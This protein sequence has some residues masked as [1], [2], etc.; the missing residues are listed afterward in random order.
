MRALSA[1][2]F[3]CLP[4]TLSATTLVVF[5]TPT[6]VILATDSAA[7]ELDETG[8]HHMQVDCKIRPSGRWWFVIGGFLRDSHGDMRD[9]VATS[10]ANTTTIQA[11]L[12]AIDDHSLSDHIRANRALYK[13]RQAGSP[14]MTIVI[15]DTTMIVGVFMVSLKTA[16]PFEVMVET[17]TCPGTL[18]ATGSYYLVGEPGDAPPN[19]LLKAL[20]SWFQR[21]DAAAARQFIT[22]QIAFT[23]LLARHPIDVLEITTTGARWVGREESSACASIP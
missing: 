21:G 17:G 14:L 7:V 15:A 19:P 10:I 5:R 20:P 13:G 9:V 8:K 11:A 2:A 3:V 1:L 18:C 23:P 12:A 6:A 22:E 4:V 16:D